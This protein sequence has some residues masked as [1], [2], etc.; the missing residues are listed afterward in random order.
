MQRL[1]DQV[2][3]CSCRSSSPSRRCTFVAWALSGRSRRC[4]RAHQRDRRSSSSP[5][6]ARWA[7]RRRPRSWS[8]PASGAELGI[9]IRDGEALEGAQ[10]VTAVV[11]DKTGHDHPGQAR[12]HRRRAAP[13]VRRGRAAAP[14]RRGG[15]RQ[16]APAGRGHRRPRRRRAR[17]RARRRHRL[18]GRPRT[19]IRRVRRR[20]PGAGRQRAPILTRAGIDADAAASSAD[21]ARRHRRDPRSTSPSTDSPSA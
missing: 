15:E 14:R 8:A 5:A 16:R 13:G 1:A 20:P 17:P 2:S 10:R 9:L 3:G 12:R 11:L 21:E 18:R 19:R 6:P 7:W 4:H